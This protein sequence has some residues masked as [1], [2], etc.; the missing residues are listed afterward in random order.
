MKSLLILFF[1]GISASTW[2]QSKDSLISIVID[3]SAIYNLTPVTVH[4]NTHKADSI[5][6]RA[7]YE[8]ILNY[9]KKKINMGDNKWNRTIIVMGKKITLDPQKSLSLLD[10]NSLARSIHSKKDKQKL[11]LQ[12]RV[13][14]QEQDAYI[15][16]VFTPA[17]VEKFSNMHDDDSLHLFI[18]RYA[19]SYN[20]IKIM[21][22][23]DLG[24]YILL[25]MKAFR[26]YP[27]IKD[28]IETK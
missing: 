12:K 13:I 1:S 8:P 18:A 15:Q 21:N 23:L 24:S 20:E 27:I 17:L 11:F 7:D 22:E 5:Q 16:Q 25:N 28:S 9:R 19:P 14:E 10:I 26:Q 4:T 6:N 2:A 3:T